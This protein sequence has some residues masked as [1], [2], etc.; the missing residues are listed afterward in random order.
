MSN[1]PY[2]G[3]E[4]K[5][6]LTPAPA[7]SYRA[8]FRWGDPEFFKYPKESL[9]KLMKEKFCL[10]DKYFE[11]Y[12][13]DL[14][15]DKVELPNNPCKLD[16]KHIKAIKKIVGD[17]NVSIKDFDRLDVAYGYTGYDL[18]RLRHKRI[19][20][21]PD[22]VVYP[23]TT[24]EIEEIVAYVVKH[25]IPL[26]VYGGGS[27][28]TRGVEPVKCGISLDMRKRFN[29]VINFNEVD[30]TITVQAGMSGPDLEKALQNAPE[31]FGAKRQYTCGHFPQSFEYSS[32]G[33]W[34]VTRGAG[35]N[36]TYYGTIADIVLSQRY[37]TPKG[38]I[39]TSHYSREA[40]GPS[41][42]HIM[43]GSEGTFG[44]LT[45]VT[46]R[47]FRWMPENRKRFSY[48]FKNWDIA[49]A[50]C[51]EMMQCECGYSSVFR[52]SDPEESSL[53]L[54]LYNVDE[55]PIAPLLDKFGFKDMERCMFLGFTDGEKGFSKNVARNIMKIALKHGAMPMT[56]YVT[57]SWEKGRFNDPYLRDTLMDFG[58]ITDTLEC[59]VNWS[60]MEQV[61]AD[62]RKVCHA[63]PNTV[64]T[65]HMSHCYPQGANLY[66]IFLTKMQD[67]EEFRKYHTTILDAIQ[68]SGAAISHHHG[69][70]KF[71]APWLEGFLGDN[72][73]DIIK[74]LKNHFDPDFVM[75]P[76]GTLGL[77]LKPEEKKF[78][79][80]HKEYYQND[81]G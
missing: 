66:F 10:D 1:K 51:R 28:V 30:Q 37:A 54:R 11:N 25:K 48:M 52:L 49:M 2:K 29:K 20:C 21:V 32:V 42:N 46:L 40:T 31:L 58:I 7:D 15:F 5:W 73:Y 78:L 17:D 56:G 39:Q 63:L 79:R 36:S 18:L 61:H 34:T 67:E 64:V 43:M 60:N 53:M 45:E 24:K 47:V 14:G 4:P 41:I 12:S 26:Y 50:A 68:R 55:T 72:E 16:D 80:E 8:I 65:T 75:N 74:V 3:F 62:V 6:V 76:G 81:I 70:G 33:G 69:I 59:T 38:V 22:I 27:T 35:Q 9:Y 57:R 44:V 71:F 77:D 23:S 19:D 13:D